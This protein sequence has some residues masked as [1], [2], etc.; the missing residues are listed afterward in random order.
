MAQALDIPLRGQIP[1]V[2]GIRESGDTGQ[3]AAL[4]TGPDATAFLELARR[5]AEEAEHSDQ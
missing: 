3:P 1:L 2:Q 4:G 5:L